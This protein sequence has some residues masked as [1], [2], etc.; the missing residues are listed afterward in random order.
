MS[1][2]PK[3]PLITQPFYVICV[4]LTNSPQN[5]AQ[6]YFFGALLF[7]GIA[8]AQLPF[9]D[10]FS[11]PGVNQYPYTTNAGGALTA[12]TSNT[13]QVSAGELIC[14]GCSGTPAA[15]YQTPPIPFGSAATV[16]F[17]LNIRDQGGVDGCR[18]NSPSSFIDYVDVFYSLDNGATFVQV[19]DPTYGSPALG[20][21]NPVH[22]ALP[23]DPLNGPVDWPNGG[24]TFSQGGIAPNP[25]FNTIIIR[26][27]PYTNGTNEGIFI[28]DLQVFETVVLP[29]E[30]LAFTAEPLQ[31]GNAVL[32]WTTASEQNNAGFT[33]ERSLDGIA[34][35]DLTWVSGNG[36]TN[37]VST[38]THTDNG[39]DDATRAFYRLRQQDF[40]GKTQYSQIQEVNFSTTADWTIRAYPNPTTD[41]LTVVLN[42]AADARVKLFNA[43]GQAVLTT[44]LAGR[45]TLDLSAL[46]AGTYALQVLANG[47]MVTERI[48][49]R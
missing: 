37:A 3:N 39:L 14:S 28:D 44:T 40:D 20:C 41:Q 2:D 36:T 42:G 16:D 24:F 13:F 8:W 33:I 34:F 26:V 48:I 43:V 45:Q 49:K 10:D 31:P 47:K 30:L 1:T 7:P 5:M 35:A 46:A 6:W 29:A 15:T 4:P 17:S 21:T 38:Y 18:N 12:N 25:A 27:R 19:F 11:D 32:S 22:S 9:L 23:F